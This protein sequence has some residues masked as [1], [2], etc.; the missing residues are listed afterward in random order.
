MYCFVYSCK[1]D[2]DG[3]H[4]REPDL[5]VY[6]TYTRRVYLVPRTNLIYHSRR[7]R[8][9]DGSD[10]G[11]RVR[12]DRRSTPATQAAQFGQRWLSMAHLQSVLFA[13]CRCGSHLKQTK[14]GDFTMRR[15]L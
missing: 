13:G 15:P 2:A 10:G 6:L 1:G 3:E 12:R 7:A 9:A 14:T 5:Y 11:T 4:A 8:A